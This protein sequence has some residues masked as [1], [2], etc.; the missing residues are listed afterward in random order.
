MIRGGRGGFPRSFSCPPREASA[1]R[2]SRA[3]TGLPPALG[4]RELR[5]KRADEG[6]SVPDNR[7]CAIGRCEN[8]VVLDELDDASV[9]RVE[10]NSDRTPVVGRLQK[11]RVNNALEGNVSAARPAACGETGAGE[12]SGDDIHL[13]DDL[14]EEPL[15][16][17][18]GLLLHGSD[19]PPS[20]PAC[21]SGRELDR[22]T[23]DKRQSRADDETASTGGDVKRF[24]DL[25]KDW[26]GFEKLVAELH[27]TGDVEVQHNVT[28]VGK[29]GVERQ[30]DVLVTHRQGV[31]EHRIIIECKLWTSMVKR[32]QVDQVVAAKNDLN[33]SQAVIFSAKGFQEG[34]LG[35]AKH[36][37]VRLFNVR[38]VDDAEWG[39]PGRRVELYLQIFAHTLVDARIENSTAVCF[40]AQPPANLKLELV[41][42]DGEGATKTKVLER[43]GAKTQ[44]PTLEE[45]VHDAAM[46]ALRQESDKITGLI[47]TGDDVVVH[48]L[49]NLSIDIAPPAQIPGAGYLINIP[50]IVVGFGVEV[51][52][53]KLSIDRGDPYLYALVVED[54][55][56]G[57]ATTVARSSKDDKLKSEPL[58][59]SVPPPDGDDDKQPLQNG[60]ILKMV[61]RQMFRPENLQDLK[62]GESR[63]SPHP[64][65]ATATPA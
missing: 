14:V 22:R 37:N 63:I 44:F 30:V 59:K 54:A 60:S 38:D 47:G 21:Q 3:G 50:R 33:A 46:Q 5:C 65:K 12:L 2:R 36:E 40:S 19:A 10:E 49:K 57:A 13:R 51:S 62:R 48:W 55:V 53:T 20:P 8:H 9:L 45:Y 27:R 1:R 28:L 26:D 31:Y 35:Y 43:P 25:V 15:K 24:A 39:A 41:L 11:K 6:R 34:A 17:R 29:S 23:P 4:A 32:Q 7:P 52:E 18:G 61:M 64:K 56:S 16:L 42:G 58:A